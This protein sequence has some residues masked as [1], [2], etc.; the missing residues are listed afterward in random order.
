L[1]EGPAPGTFFSSGI[2]EITYQY[3]DESGNSSICSF[4]IDVR[5]DETPT[6]LCPEDIS[7]EDPIVVYTQPTF[8]DNCGAALALIA[9]PESGDVFPH[10]NTEVTYLA[11]DE[12]GNS[13]E[14]SFNVLVNS[15]PIAENDSIYFAEEDSSI[16]IDILDNDNDPDG[17][18]LF[19][20]AASA[21]FGTVSIDPNGTL[22][23]DI[24]PADWCGTDTIS[25]TICDVFGACDS[26]IVLVEVEC[27]FDIF[28]PEGFSPNGDGVNDTFVIT[29]LEDYP[30]HELGVFN[31]WGH[32][33]YEAK[34]YQNDWAGVSDSP[35]T[36]GSGVL[37]KGTYFYVLRLEPQGKIVKG[38]I[39][40]NH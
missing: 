25:Y 39:F 9:G 4:V 32:K 36:L 33:V 26:A 29:G 38:Y 21:N 7:Q 5:D 35:L 16:G 6:I 18:N 40:L 1:V 20:T 28:V 10:G 31:R 8:A 27:F 12:A 11:F 17:D 19:I 3:T 34:N 30:D 37:P 22:F 14:C 15:P 24:N 13:V 23:Y 2:T